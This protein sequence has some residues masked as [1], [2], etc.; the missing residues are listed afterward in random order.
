MSDSLPS[1]G[2]QSP[3]NSP[4]QNTGVGSLSLLQGIFP[5][6]GLNAGLPHC[7]WILYQ[8][9]H[10]GSLLSDGARI[11]IQTCNCVRAHSWS[12]CCAIFCPFLFP[13]HPVTFWGLSVILLECFFNLSLFFCFYHPALNF[14][15][16]GMDY[17]HNLLTGLSAFLFTVYTVLPVVFLSTD[18]ILSLYS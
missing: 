9:S 16:L 7:R 12:L 14:H 11:Q 8:P 15:Y 1:H 3:W 5:I 13:P 18:L 4:G 17:N 6:Q 10:Q 2:L